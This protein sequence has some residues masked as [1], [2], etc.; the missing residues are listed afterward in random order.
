M[1]PSL[2]DE[3]AGLNPF[4]EFYG[5]FQKSRTELGESNNRKPE[6]IPLHPVR[7]AVIDNGVD[8]YSF[9][10]KIKRGISFVHHN[11]KEHNW[12]IASDS[13]GTRMA[14]IIQ[15]IDPFCEI[16]PIKVGDRTKDLIPS[17]VVEVRH[18]LNG[19]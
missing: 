9:H 2:P 1:H 14:R 7:I 3:L 8:D 13:H 11:G 10:K 16:Y 6:G 12:F 18:Q 17:R 15:Q 5:G 19:C 4:L